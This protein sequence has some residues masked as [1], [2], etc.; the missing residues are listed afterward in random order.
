MASSEP[1]VASSSQNPILRGAEA[2]PALEG[3]SVT[4]L[5]WQ[6]LSVPTSAVSWHAA[7]RAPSLPR[8][9]QRTRV[10]GYGFNVAGLLSLSRYSKHPFFSLKMLLRAV[11]MQV[12]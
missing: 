2:R 12:H 3:G 1:S 11:E 5:K 4:D 10:K 8:A 6:M 7:A 9:S